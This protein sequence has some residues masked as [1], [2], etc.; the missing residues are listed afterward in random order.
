P[1]KAGKHISRSQAAKFSVRAQVPILW[2][3]ALTEVEM[4]FGRP[5]VPEEIATLHI[6]LS[7]AKPGPPP[8]SML[9]SSPVNQL[10]PTSAWREPEGA[11]PVFDPQHAL[12]E[13]A[14]SRHTVGQN[15]GRLVGLRLGV[16]QNEIGEGRGDGVHVFAF[17][18]AS[19]ELVIYPDAADVER[20]LEY[21]RIIGG[22]ENGEIHRA[23]RESGVEIFRFCG[24]VFGQCVFDTAA[25]RPASAGRVRSS[26]ERNRCVAYLIL[27][28]RKSNAAGGVNKSA[29]EC[30]AQPSPDGGKAGKTG[31][32]GGLPKGGIN[33]DALGLRSEGEVSLKTVNEVGHLPVVS[34]L[35]A[36]D[37]TRPIGV[38]GSRAAKEIGRA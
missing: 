37:Q 20:I 25:R 22:A 34:R 36:A 5:V 26:G 27:E 17:S 23:A 12:P 3:S 15:D 35:R 13:H 11:N 18:A 29:V 32:E 4:A 21:Q 7:L 24:P 2:F 33:G 10:S 9:R 8:R 6:V 19:S 38:V 14:I 1:A 16:E 31:V 30:Q 28:V